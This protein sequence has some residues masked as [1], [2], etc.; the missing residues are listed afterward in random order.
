MIC[1]LREREREI[2][3]K[4]VTPV[5]V[6]SD[7]SM[8]IINA[9]LREFNNESL[10]EYFERGFQIVNGKSNTRR[11]SENNPSCMFGTYDANN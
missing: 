4:E 1:T 11:S 5:L 10:E 9:C 6:M 2:F 8:A 3:K 7:F